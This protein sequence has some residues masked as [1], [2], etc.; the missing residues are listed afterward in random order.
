MF[1]SFK[2]QGWTLEQFSEALLTMAKK[3][4]INWICRRDGTNYFSIA[5]LAVGFFDYQINKLYYNN[6]GE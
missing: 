3:G 5:F 1:R 4:A 6:W 2:K